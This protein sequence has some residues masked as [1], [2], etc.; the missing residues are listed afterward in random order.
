MRYLK[1]YE[2]FGSPVGFDDMT[3]DI[4]NKLMEIKDE[5]LHKGSVDSY[6]PHN[7]DYQLDLN[8]SIDGLY[9]YVYNFDGVYIGGGSEEEV[10]TTESTTINDELYLYHSN[11]FN[12]EELSEIFNLLNEYSNKIEVNSDGDLSNE[13]SFIENYI[14]D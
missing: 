5:D 12:R 8:M 3:R 4:F 9:L 6:I 10:N 1:L 7:D 11:D 14:E 2:S 13:E